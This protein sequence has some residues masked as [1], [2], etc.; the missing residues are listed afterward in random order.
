LDEIVTISIEL[1][2]SGLGLHDT[3][4]TEAPWGEIVQLVRG[5]LGHLNGQYVLPLDERCLTTDELVARAEAH[6]EAGDLEEAERLYRIALKIDRLDAVIPF[7]LGNVLDRLGRPKEALLSYQQALGRD[8]SFVEA[9][10]NTAAVQEALGS[11]DTAEATLLRALA[12]SPE[13]PLALH[14]LGLLLTRAERYSDAVPVW[15]RYLATHPAGQERKFALRMDALCRR[16]TARPDEP[17]QQ[18][19]G[20]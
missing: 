20:H 1:R 4:V 19:S 15:Q 10:I 14:N 11:R 16:A 18:D 13:Q 7:N 5:R 17:G 3:S 6:E 9:W 12:C 8:P 2:Q